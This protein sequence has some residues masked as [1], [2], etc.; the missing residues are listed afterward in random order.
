[1]NIFD[2]LVYTFIMMVLVMCRLLISFGYAFI[3]VLDLTC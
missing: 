3:N 1:M 2:K